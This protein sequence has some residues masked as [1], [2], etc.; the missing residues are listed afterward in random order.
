MINFLIEEYNVRFI[1]MNN[2]SDKIFMKRKIT[3]TEAIRLLYTAK[4]GI[5]G[6]KAIDAMIQNAVHIIV[7]AF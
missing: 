3:R 5:P 7:E 1:G 4:V 2:Y 6:N